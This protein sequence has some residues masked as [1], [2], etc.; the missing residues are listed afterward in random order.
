M[1]RSVVMLPKDGV[2]AT[3]DTDGVEFQSGTPAIPGTVWLRLAPANAVAL[4]LRVLTHYCS[5]PQPVSTKSQGSEVWFPRSRDE[6]VESIKTFVAAY[7]KDP[8]GVHIPKAMEEENCRWLKTGYGQ[9]R[10][11]TIVG[12]KIHWDATIFQLVGDG[13]TP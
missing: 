9:S 5:L 4:A 8:V 12:M 1:D 13:T 10:S 11:D 3:V 2:F 7:G 6:F